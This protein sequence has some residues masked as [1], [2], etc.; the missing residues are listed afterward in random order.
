M[1]LDKR[2]QA[3]GVVRVLRPT[4]AA[5][6]AGRTNVHATSALRERPT[7]THREWGLR[8]RTAPPA[9]IG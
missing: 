2:L 9:F 6:I 5:V 7:A 1:L 8:P 4:L 3:G